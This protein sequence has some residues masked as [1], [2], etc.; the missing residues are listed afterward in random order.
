MAFPCY[1]WRRRARRE[2]H[3]RP[4]QRLIRCRPGL[5]ARHA[6]QQQ[7]FTSG[8]GAGAL[9]PVSSRAP[10]PRCAV[11]VQSRSC[12]AAAS[13]RK[14]ERHCNAAT[15][16]ATPMRRRSMLPV[17]APPA[18]RHSVS[19]AE[20][21]HAT[22]Q[23][24]NGPALQRRHSTGE[25]NATPVDARPVNAPPARRHSVSGAE[26]PHAAQQADNGPA[27]R[28][29]HSTG[30]ANATPVDGR[31]VK[32]P[33]AR[34]HSLSGSGET[35]RPA[36]PA[37]RHSLSALAEPHSGRTASVTDTA[38][39]LADWSNTMLQL[40]DQISERHAAALSAD[41]KPR[42]RRSRRSVS[43]WSALLP[44]ASRRRARRRR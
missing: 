37:R 14:A 40:V 35:P 24:D 33:P 28:R 43:G 8:R 18:R 4:Q 36:A 20:T 7:Q 2:R 21:P 15:P 12:R 27:L 30:E 26:T 3:E 11:S 42:W 44:K 5:G 41:E 13:R 19:G 6:A 32:P 34:R 39:S 25:A 22:Q 1:R 16:P 29:R 9:L 23:A 31:P 38:A 10:L 17:N